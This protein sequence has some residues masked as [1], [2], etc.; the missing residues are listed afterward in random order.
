MS[1]KKFDVYWKPKNASKYDCMTII[2][3]SYLT[4]KALDCSIRQIA[5]ISN[6]ELDDYGRTE[7]DE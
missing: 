4:G 7:Q 1:T 3:P 2:V 6:M 5:G